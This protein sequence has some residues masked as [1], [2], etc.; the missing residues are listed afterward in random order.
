MNCPSRFFSLDSVTF[1]V[2]IVIYLFRGLISKF[3]RSNSYGDW[4]STK[5]SIS[6]DEHCLGAES[7]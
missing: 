5:V 2:A 1:E 6:F 3:L 4:I 7:L